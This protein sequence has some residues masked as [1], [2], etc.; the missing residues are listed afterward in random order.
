MIDW[1]QKHKKWLVI[2][3]WISTISFIAAGMVGWG[4]YNFG[5]GSSEVAK[6]GSIKITQTQFDNYYRQLF[7]QYN[8]NGDLDLQKAK[9]LGLDKIVLDH[10]I[11]YAL[12]ENFALD[13]GL[14]VSQK[15]IFDEISK[16]DAFKKDSKFDAEI[17]KAV[18]KQN[19][20]KPS[21]F[22]TDIT[23]D[24]LIRKVATILPQ[25]YITKLEREAFALPL[26]IEDEL[27]I[28]MLN[29][30][31]IKVSLKQ[32][33]VKD[34]WEKNKQKYQYPAE[35]KVEYIL[36]NDDEQKPTKEELLALYEES[37]SRYL[38]EKG[39]FKSFDSVKQE[40]LKEQKEILAED[41]ALREYIAL[42]KA[43]EPYGQEEILIEGD[44]KFGLEVFEK[45]EKANIGDTFKPI[46]VEGGYLTLKLNEKKPSTV[47]KFDD[48]MMEAK[49]HL[50]EERRHEILIEQA[51]ELSKNELEGQNIGYVGLL[52]RK[53]ISNLTDEEWQ[54]FLS[55]V[56]GSTQK[57]GYV[58]LGDRAIVFEIINQ[59]MIPKT[60]GEEKQMLDTLKSQIIDEEFYQYLRKQYKI[61]NI[62]N[63][64]QIN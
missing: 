40:V 34:Y 28:K 52:E 35:Y 25:S 26:Q 11:R 49:I 62:Q 48:A 56:L 12:V 50:M 55:Q 2:T 22:E 39:D 47:K 41:T 20:L 44:K 60:N 3:I 8:Q 21:D 32:Q 5:L 16:F 37:K 54:I 1:M 61:T 42:K 29:Q 23:K 24:L 58:I 18:L 31:Q 9:E 19:N 14:R 6:V 46:R 17:Y 10:L 13:L 45:L 38:N 57:R 30:D 7:N 4:S 43:Q 59:K 64:L 53:K 63:N 36:I 27:K 33:E 51:K 15:E